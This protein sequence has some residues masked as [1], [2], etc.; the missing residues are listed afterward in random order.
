MEDME[1]EEGEV[2]YKKL[3]ELKRQ[4]DE[5]AQKAKE[6]R[7][8]E[9]AERRAKEAAQ[10]ELASAIK[11]KDTDRLEA[12]I[13]AAKSLKVSGIGKAEVALAKLRED[14]A[15]RAAVGASLAKSAKRQSIMSLGSAIAAAKALDVDAS[16]QAALLERLQAEQADI[17]RKHEEL[18]KRQDAAKDAEDYEQA[19]A[20]QK[21]R[22]ALPRTTV[23][24]RAF[25]K[26][27][28]AM[29]ERSVAGLEAALAEAKAHNEKEEEKKHK[30]N[31]D[32]AEAL[33]EVQREEQEA[34]AAE[35]AKWSHLSKAEK[36]KK[37]Y[38]FSQSNNVEDLRIL[39]KD[40]A[41]PEDY[42]VS[43][44]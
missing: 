12:A 23:A 32:A 21:E 37:V 30:V 39:L 41:G 5:A 42:K 35:A 36:G 10:K 40:G 31:T 19:K 8:K 9:L 34:A 13:E 38:E 6:K 28:E 24:R 26:L 20:L 44:E 16:E 29:E 2:D 27:R 4:R 18:K 1:E 3:K 15:K 22:L 17:D 7:E 43:E 11:S 33:L 25:E 14:A